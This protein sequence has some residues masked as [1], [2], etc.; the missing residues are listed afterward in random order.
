MPKLRLLNGPREG[1]IFSF[2]RT[3]VVG[4]G[5][6]SDLVIDD[7]SVSRRHAQLVEDG[8]HFQ[9]SDLGSANGTL[10]NGRPVSTTLRLTAGDRLTFGRVEAVYQDLPIE[11]TVAVVT[12]ATMDTTSRVTFSTPLNEAVPYMR[13]VPGVRTSQ[14]I[15]D[16]RI[17][18]FNEL[19]KVAGKA[20]DE[21]KLLAFVLEQMFG[22]FPQVERAIVLTSE[23]ESDRLLPRAARNR[24][25][26]VADM[27]VSY[28]L[29]G[30]AV[31]RREAILLMDEQ[32]SPQYSEA[33]SIRLAG[34]R[35]A[36]CAPLVFDD[37]TYGVL[38]I[39]N[40]GR[41]APLGRGDVEV[42]RAV[43]CQLGMAI[44]YARL[45]TTLLN[46]ALLEHDLDFARRI[47]Q[48]FFPGRPPDVEG[49]SFE[50]SCLPALSIGGDFYDF[51][52][53]GPSLVGMVIGDVSGKG[54]SAALYGARVTSELRNVATDRDP[55]GILA[56]L[57]E[58]LSSLAQ[59]GMFVTAAVGVLDLSTNRIDVAT[60][61][62]PRPLLLTPAGDVRPIGRGG[63]TPLGVGHVKPY[64]RADYELKP[65]EAMILYTDGVTDAMNAD[66]EL[67]GD[68]RFED[69]LRRTGSRAE[70]HR[71]IL[72]AINEFTGERPRFD[73]ITVV[74]VRRKDA[75]API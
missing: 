23:S 30:D 72:A 63:G 26:R 10:L 52:E 7:S 12:P 45:H 47:Q 38:Q 51:L 5:R 42:V 4:R 15:V 43:A 71:G 62:H 19:T 59:E 13:D 16:R 56:R 41:A 49:F 6:H 44:A 70:I 48:Q 37:R 2:D 58:R 68:K 61:G 24:L 11:R 25:G 32:N 29:I 36:I 60:A 46:R 1:L 64:A 17:Q 73:D 3:V 21:D 54:V 67:F 18:F 55:S 22:L 20:F 40:G 65:G 31:R 69:T 9:L 53:L 8:P 14:T 28:T 33:E 50:V 39:D 27:P 74:S 66:R 57:D 35:S 34:I 75:A